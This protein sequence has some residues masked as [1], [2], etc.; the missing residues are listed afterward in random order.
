[1]AYRIEPPAAVE[2]TDRSPARLSPGVGLARDHGAF[3]VVGRLWPL[4]HRRRF[5]AVFG[6]K[7]DHWLQYTVAGLLAGNGAAQIL[8]TFPPQVSSTRA[9][10]E[11]SPR[12]GCWRSI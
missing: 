4:L 2:V 8:A 3:N 10:L 11:S 1:M 5:E 6:P 12:H 7:K 9:A